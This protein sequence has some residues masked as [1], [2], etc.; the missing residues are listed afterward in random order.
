MSSSTLK[1][2]ILYLW[3]EMGYGALSIIQERVVETIHYLSSG[4]VT[5]LAFFLARIIAIRDEKEEDKSS[6]TQSFV[7]HW[8][9]ESLSYN[10]FPV[11]QSTREIENSTGTR[12][13]KCPFQLEANH[14]ESVEPEIHRIWASEGA[15]VVE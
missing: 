12:L 2:I 10:H 1:R 6:K 14:E 5:T 8:Y 11:L 7:H 15:A 3:I 13:A 9:S 4:I